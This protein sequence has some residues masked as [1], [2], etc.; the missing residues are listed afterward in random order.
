LGLKALLL[1]L[2]L[3]FKHILLTRIVKNQLYFHILRDVINLTLFF[4]T[5]P[6]TKNFI[7]ILSQTHPLK[8]SLHEDFLQ[9]GLEKALRKKGVFLRG[10][11]YFCS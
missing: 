6:K 4:T 7:L 5:N 8:Y 11:K 3:L 1:L 9:E 2:L 10:L